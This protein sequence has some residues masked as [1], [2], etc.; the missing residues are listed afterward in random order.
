MA[1]RQTQYMIREIARKYADVL[2]REI[3]L[4]GLYVYGSYARGEQDQ[5]SDIDIA[6]V[7]DDFTGDM[8]EDTF[9]LMKLRRQVDTRIE[10]HPF[11]Q[12]D[13]TEKNPMAREVMRTG[14]R[15]V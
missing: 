9:R 12:S 5:D 7:A 1:D 13:F 2:R 6:V 10:P 15:I 11:R 3:N 8:V 4:L 14:I